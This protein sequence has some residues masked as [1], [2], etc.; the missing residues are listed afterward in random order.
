MGFEAPRTVIEDE[1]DLSCVGLRIEATGLGVR[2]TWLS[3]LD[4]LLLS[5]VNEGWGELCRCDVEEPGEPG[6]DWTSRKC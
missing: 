2:Q 6:L 4:W 5:L 1:N 3:G